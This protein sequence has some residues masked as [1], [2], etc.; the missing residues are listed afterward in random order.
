MVRGQLPGVRRRQD[1]PPRRGSDTPAPDDVPE[2]DALTGLVAE[3]LDPRFEQGQHRRHLVAV[4]APCPLP[5][6]IEAARY[7]RGAWCRDPA[8]ARLRGEIGHSCLP[9]EADEIGH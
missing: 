3:A 1:P 2:I 5:F 4:A 7:L 8:R 9:V 6:A